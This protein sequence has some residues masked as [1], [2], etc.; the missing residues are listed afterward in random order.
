MITFL[1][2]VLGRRPSDPDV[3]T[4]RVG[5]AEGAIDE[6]IGDVQ[7]LERDYSLVTELAGEVEQLRALVAVLLAA[8]PDA[9]VLVSELAHLKPYG[10][11]PVH[12]TALQAN[13][14]AARDYD[15]KT[16][17]SRHVTTALGDAAICA[18]TAI[19]QF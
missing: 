2:N 8:I 11:R 12:F 18:H 14:L 16:G 13:G 17:D 10:Y 7:Q 6:L 9:S 19:T 1:R 3:L 4:N 5:T 15:P